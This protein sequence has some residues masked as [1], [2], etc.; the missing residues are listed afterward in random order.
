MMMLKKTLW[1]GSAI[2]VTTLTLAGCATV[3]HPHPDDP[4]ERYNRAMF[5][6]NE[7]VDKVVLKPLATG[8][9]TV[10]PLPVKT[11]V[12]NFF[13]NLGDI[14]TGINNFLQ[15][16]GGDGRSDT[17]RVLINSTLGIF[18][19]F[20]VA[21]DMGFEKHQEDFG[22]TL[23]VWGVGK[24]PYFVLPFLGPRTLRDAAALPVDFYADPV[25]H[26]SDVASRNALVGLR[27]V[28]ER[29][30]LLGASRAVEEGSLDKYGYIRDF[31]LQRRRYE[32]YDGRPPRERFD[33]ARSAPIQPIG[34]SAIEADDAATG[35]MRI[36]LVRAGG[37]NLNEQGREQ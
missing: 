14:W 12:G 18:G 19:L 4:W 2:L 26:L 22:Q 15:G 20:D 21:T 10:A 11:G 29:A 16:K 5:S 27:V 9:D 32:I 1:R 6:F 28:H 17:A 35:S 24:G 34:L 33:D 13:G 30:A 36:E 37:G 23:A 31:Y 8:Y 25:A 7:G 3:K